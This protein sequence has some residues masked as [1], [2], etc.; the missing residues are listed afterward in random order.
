M[1]WLGKS[2]GEKIDCAPR[3]DLF[4]PCI[5]TATFT[6]TLRCMYPYTPLLNLLKHTTRLG[7]ERKVGECGTKT[8]E[9]AETEKKE[10]LQ[11]LGEEKEDKL[12]RE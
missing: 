6:I 12:V 3:S 4:F 11:N 8:R 2:Q 7:V 9:N 5:V 10:K 1:Q